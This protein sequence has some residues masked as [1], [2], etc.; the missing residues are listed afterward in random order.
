MG[1]DLRVMVILGLTLLVVIALTAILTKSRPRLARVV[2]RIFLAGTLVVI[3][4]VTLHPNISR[5][6][7][8]GNHVNLVPLEG[9]WQQVNN[10]DPMIGAVNILGNVALFVP[11][12]LF[13]FLALDGGS[14]LR[15][16]ACGVLL[17]VTIETLQLF[18]GRAADIDDVLLNTLGALV[19]AWLGRALLGPSGRRSKELGAA[20]AEG[21]RAL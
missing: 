12:G 3:V 15:A 9:L 6:S 17:S 8:T 1:I 4:V 21:S 19:G 20:V 5:R 14:V 11:L 7:S 18:T 2:S 13:V 10:L 16:T